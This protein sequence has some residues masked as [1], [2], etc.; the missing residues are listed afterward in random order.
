MEKQTVYIL[1]SYVNR[2]CY[3]LGVASSE[4]R[5]K[6]W[7]EKSTGAFDPSIEYDYRECVVDDPKN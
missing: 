1:L 7:V 5:A 3:P 6:K 4:E 2:Q